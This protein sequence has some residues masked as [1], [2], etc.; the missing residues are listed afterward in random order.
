MTTEPY[1]HETGYHAAMA[2]LEQEIATT[3]AIRNA[4]ARD[5]AKEKLEM[6]ISARD[7]IL[8][9]VGTWAEREMRAKSLMMALRNLYRW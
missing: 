4:R 3:R 7:E 6:L 8:E 5:A 1:T 2:R 9:T